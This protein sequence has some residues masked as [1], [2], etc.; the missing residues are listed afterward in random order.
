M[1]ENHIYSQSA[2]PSSDTT[3]QEVHTPPESGWTRPKTWFRSEYKT[4]RRVFLSLVGLMVL[5]VVGFIVYATWELP[6]MQ[7]IEDPQS[8]LS[9]QLISADG[10]VLQKFYSRENRVSVPL[11]EISPYVI[12]ALIA[13]EDVR[14]YGHAGVDPKY[15]FTIAVNILR[16]EKRGG[17]TID[18]QLARNL[19]AEI[20]D[21]GTLVRKLREY[22]IAAYLE[23]RFTKEEILAAY[24]NTVNIYGTSYGV[25][26]TA[27][28]LFDKKAKDLTIEEAALIVGMLKGQGVFNPFRHPERSLARRNVVIDQMVKYGVLNPEEINVDSIKAIPLVLAEQG[29]EHVR[30]LAPYFREYVREQLKKWCDENGYN[31]YTDGLRVYTT[32][33]SRM[34][35]HLEEAVNEHMSELQKTFN[36]KIKGNEPYR[37]DPGIIDNFMRMSR[38][39]QLA[40][41]AG[42]SDEEIDR[43]FRTRVKMTIFDWEGEKE[44]EMTP[45]DSIKYYA[46]FL[47]TGVMS[48]DPNNG[49][50]KAWVGGINYKYFKY[51]H[52]AKSKR[53]VG[54]TFKPFVYGAA[55]ENGWQPCDRLLNQ[56]VYF[57]MPDGTRWAPANSGKNIGGLMSLKGGLAASENMITAGLMKE[58]KPPVVVEFAHRMGIDSELDPVPSLCLG[59]TELSVYE[60]TK[61][62]A[63]FASHGLRTEPIIITRIEDKYGNVLQQFTPESERVLPVDKAHTIIE[64][65]KEV[66]NNGTA[67]RLRFKYNFKNEIGG[68]TGTTQEHADGWF[69]GITP[70]LVTGVW[71]GNADRR[72]HFPSIKDGQGANMALPIFALYMQK[73][74]DDPAIGLPMD[75][76]EVPE[77]Y[78]V[79]FSCPNTFKE[80]EVP[81]KSGPTSSDDI[82]DF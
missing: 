58:L 31:L 23:R 20:G 68:K 75:G 17:S 51:D 2:V 46:H 4:I 55:I 73:V 44:V 67:I 5:A 24:L 39:Y 28:R 36:Q 78:D 60:M 72:M 21:Q 49:H 37:K 80:E 27:N 15:F 77:G 16:G 18:M 6:P 19:Y 63:T 38:R 42:K 25:E 71:V 43:E 53:Q 56:P 13:T 10:L 26:T 62:Y 9:T 14:F 52:V 66:V 47:E 11:N 30:G 54:S 69:M 82:S 7:A 3:Q 33:D 48:V 57:D 50:V 76:F 45:R 32:L 8:D 35:T 29:Q 81:E 61:A 22:F 65:L 34:Q 70:N 41:Q 12:D 59:T 1:E 64:L 40:K 74:Y 79:N